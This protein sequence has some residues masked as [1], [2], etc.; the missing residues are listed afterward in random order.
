MIV[1]IRASLQLFAEATLSTS[2]RQAMT[3][4]SLLPWYS[5][6]LAYVPSL[7]LV[8][9]QAIVLM[10]VCCAFPSEVGDRFIGTTGTMGAIGGGGD[11]GTTNFGT[12]FFL[13]I[14]SDVLVASGDCDLLRRLYSLV[15]RV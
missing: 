1:W 14:G 7:A 8:C 12:F 3:S 10:M 15:T 9:I 6:N 13:T 2:S 5:L 4:S 11:N